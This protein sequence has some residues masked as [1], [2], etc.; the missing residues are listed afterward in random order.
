[1]F[2]NILIGIISF[3]LII[4]IFKLLNRNYQNSPI[5]LF[6]SFSLII[7]S[8]LIFKEIN[9]LESFLLWFGFCLLFYS[10]IDDIYNLSIDRRIPII[11]TI[12]FFFISRNPIEILISFSIFLILII[13]L[14]LT[15]EIFLGIGDV[16]ILLPLLI[17]TDKYFIF[18]S[19][20]IASL[21]GLTYYLIHNNVNIIILKKDKID[22]PFVPFLTLGFLLVQYDNYIYLLYI[23]YFL[24]FINL[25]LLPL[26]KLIFKDKTKRQP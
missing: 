8:S 26:L 25:I 14:K 17:I 16:Y 3:C 18:T 15:D 12:I 11:V 24:I 13:I 2:F 20:I 6:L 23:I 10:S 22:I 1:M 4:F 7:F 9:D 5:K 19:L 21:I